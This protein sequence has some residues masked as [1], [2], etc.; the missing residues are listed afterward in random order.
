MNR[1]SLTRQG[2]RGAVLLVTLVLL[3]VVTLLGV[4]TISSTTLELKM[5]SNNQQRQLVFQ[6][7]EAALVA[8]EKQLQ[9]GG[10]PLTAV[11]DC[12]SG[13]SGC[14]EETCAGGLCFNGTYAA[15]DDQW[16]C[17]LDTSSPPPEKPW[18]DSALDVFNNAGKY[19]TVTVG[20]LSS[21]VKYITEF[22]CFVEKGNGSV[23]DNT[24]PNNG[25]PLFRFTAL[26]TNNS[27][28][29]QVALQSTYRFNE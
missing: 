4:G 21:N 24:N 11:Q 29:V 2:Q 27:G 25:A 13:S 6:A 12:A 26:A 15:G 23:F 28:D 18:R 9:F 14:Y 8:A 17:T 16:D 7:A 5:A 3:L 10:V 19:L 1:A 22:L 20:G